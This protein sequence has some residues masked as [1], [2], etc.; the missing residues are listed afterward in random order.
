M[1]GPG[2]TGSRR[3]QGPDWE[4]LAVTAEIC[5]SPSTDE[6][7]KPRWALLDYPPWLNGSVGRATVLTV[8]CVC[9]LDSIQST[10]F[11][12]T[13]ADE[14]TFISDELQLR[15]LGRC[16]AAP[17]TF[18]T[19]LQNGLCHLPQPRAPSVQ[20]QTIWCFPISRQCADSAAVQDVVTSD[21]LE[22]LDTNEDA[23]RTDRALLLQ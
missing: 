7:P 12:K 6:K 9:L 8:L 3:N 15:S 10:T 5:S 2:R 20:L 4:I 17:H 23:H 16:K 11:E 14:A 21:H 22:D 19:R 18:A 13:S 1:R